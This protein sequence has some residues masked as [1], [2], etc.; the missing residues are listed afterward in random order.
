MNKYLSCRSTEEQQTDHDMTVMEHPKNKIWAVFL[1][2]STRKTLNPARKN[3][4]FRISHV[5][6]IETTDNSKMPRSNLDHVKADTRP[7]VIPVPWKVA[8]LGNIMQP[9]SV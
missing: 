5:K 6:S 9:C 7:G 1:A 4:N 3:I 2:T 8:Y